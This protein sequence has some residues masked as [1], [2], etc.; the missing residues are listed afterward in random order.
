MR[1]RVKHYFKE[2]APKLFDKGYKPIPIRPRSKLPFM[3][4]G[5]SWQVDITKD[6][7]QKWA[8]S[9]KGA[10]GVALTGLGGIDFDITN[11]N[12]SNKLVKYLKDNIDQE[13]LIR[14]GQAPK[15][16]VPVSSS[17]D[18]QKKWKDTWYD[19]SGKK[20]EIEFLSPGDQYFVAFGIHPDTGEEYKWIDDKSVCDTSADTIATLDEID[21]AGIEDTFDAIAEGIGWTRETINKKT[22]KTKPKSSL[23]IDDQLKEIKIPGEMSNNAGLAELTT[24]LKLL[25]SAWADDRDNWITIGA[26]IH[27][28][29]GGINE[30]WLIFD[31]WSQRSKKYVG[32]KDTIDRWESFSKDK[33]IKDGEGCST[34]GTIIHILKEAGVWEQAKKEGTAAR[35][36]TDTQKN[37]RV[38]NKKTAGI[39]EQMNKRHAV[40]KIG[41]KCRIMDESTSLD[42]GVNLG[43]L[44]VPDFHVLYSNRFAADPKDPK[45]KKSISKIW[46]NDPCRRELKGI[47]FEPGEENV[48]GYY[49][50]WKGLSIKP[51]R[52][53]W[54]IFKDHIYNVIAGGNKE[55]GEWI[56][57][58]IAR[59]VQDPGGR[60]PGTCIV[61]RGGQGTGKGVFVNT[62]GEL[63]G[64]HYLPVSHASQIAGRFNSH[65]TNKLFVFI[66][67]GFWAGDKKAEGVLKS[68]ITEPYLAIEQ[69]GVDIIRIKNNINLV[70]ASN[71]D[72]VVPANLQERRF[73]V[74]DVGDNKQGDKQYFKDLMDQM[75]QGGGLQ[76]MLY[77]LLKMDISGIDLSVFE[78]TKGLYEQ[79]IHS[80]TTEMQYWH[81]RLQ[82]GEILSYI[83]DENDF[84]NY[85]GETVLWGEVKSKEQYQDYLKFAEQVKERYPA[86]PTQLGIFL[87]KICPGVKIF[88]KRVGTK[89]L[90]HRK[91]QPL[92]ECRAEFERQIKYQIEWEFEESENTFQF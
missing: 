10:G 70:M 23:S 3:S 87:K 7:V 49:N 36:K 65:L 83:D 61:L 43:F 47:V 5:E 56:V 9:S 62:I 74:L 51:K 57:A 88:K 17:S 91:F 15:F 13:I 77:D 68:I 22:K 19:K 33:G 42:G 80:M 64:D 82:D 2:I 84:S 1:F 30:G 52:G 41:S 35:E 90:S 69:K 14:I 53:S 31:Q 75:Y 78:Q 16:L 59:M 27:H 24:W 89:I 29:T 73:C 26:A 25:P 32:R 45:K 55:I 6:I 44:S 60:R 58:W 79:K 92:C 71:S 37:E 72:W 40:I 81:E 63:F 48:E 54:N 28:E 67:E 50:M 12:V 8:G 34:R 85:V 21:L 86:S 11:K 18:I 76:A 46:I 4:K 20:H 39:I 38:N 66:D